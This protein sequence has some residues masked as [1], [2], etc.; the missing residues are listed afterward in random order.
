VQG[1]IVEGFRL[2]AGDRPVTVKLSGLML[3]TS[4]RNLVVHKISST[5]ILATKLSAF[6]GDKREMRIE[7]VVFH[8]ATPTARCIKFEPMPNTPQHINIVDCKFLGPFQSAID[9]GDYSNGLRIYG[10][11]FAHGG[12]GIRFSGISPAVVDTQ[13]S[14]NSFFQCENGI[15]FSEH[16]TTFSRN[17]KIQRN[18]FANMSGPE[19]T[20]DKDLNIQEF[21]AIIAGTQAVHGNWTSRPKPSEAGIDII[22]KN[23]R[24]AVDFVFHSTDPS[25]ERFLAPTPSSPHRQMGQ[26]T[27]YLRPVVGAVEFEAPGK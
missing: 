7:N 1:L 2:E 14:N 5:G 21:Q 27:D 8:G 25:H 26:R 9:L 3:G 24:W 17:F 22:Q 10:N 15:A 11:V 16:P 4:L 23:G 20:V 19:L 6:R 12:A 13:I 18:L